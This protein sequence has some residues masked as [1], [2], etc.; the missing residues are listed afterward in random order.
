MAGGDDGVGGGI[1]T[2]AR[3]DFWEGLGLVRG[4]EPNNLPGVGRF[5]ITAGVWG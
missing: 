5:I 4:F 2:S 1:E 3:A